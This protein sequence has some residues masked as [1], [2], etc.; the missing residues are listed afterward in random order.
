MTAQRIPLW[1]A[2]G[3]FNV[4]QHLQV[5]ASLLP[6]WTVSWHMALGACHI[7]RY[8]SGHGQLGGQA[9]S[10]RTWGQNFPQGGT[11]PVRTAA[12]LLLA[13]VW[14]EGLWLEQQQWLA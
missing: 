8:G 5:P 2:H 9:R 1:P 6:G 10:W 11:A 4:H 12:T 7:P 13:L 3:G 14:T